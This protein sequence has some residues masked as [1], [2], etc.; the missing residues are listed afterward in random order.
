MLAEGGCCDVYLDL[1]G[2]EGASGG[3]FN[4]DSQS[5]RVPKRRQHFGE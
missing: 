5:Y 3:D 2:G 1:P 4:N